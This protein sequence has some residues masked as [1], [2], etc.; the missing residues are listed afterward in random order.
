MASINTNIA[1]Y[2]AEKALKVTNRKMTTA[3]ERLSTGYKIN[4]AGD[5]PAGLA[6]TTR[7]TAQISGYEMAASHA[8][9]AISMLQTVEGALSEV[10]AVMQRM[11]QLAV[12]ATSETFSSADLAASDSE[13]Q[14]LEAEVSRIVAQTKWNTM[15]VL[16]GSGPI[17]TAKGTFL[18]QVGADS[19]MTI[20]ITLGSMS[21]KAGET[22]TKLNALAITT[23]TAA[24][25]AVSKIDGTFDD[26]NTKRATVGAFMNRMQGALDNALSMSQ[27]LT[28]TRS[29]LLDTDYA[30]ELA[31]LARLQIIQQAGNAMLAQA[32][33]QPQNVLALLR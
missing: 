21:T 5:D 7:M 15:G 2:Q 29:K 32:N 28:A 8:G 30:A 13:Y 10:A 24:A 19:G 20:G 26:L 27:N 14:Q 4:R 23:Q 1:A 9:D 6:I 11:R 22:L 25:Y 17:A 31:N 33:A 16:D 12:Q 18:I 3:M